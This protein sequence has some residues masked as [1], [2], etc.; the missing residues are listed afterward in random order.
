[1]SLGHRC[2]CGVFIGLVIVG[3]L[4]PASVPLPGRGNLLSAEAAS[5]QV[6]A[7]ARRPRRGR[8]K[9]HAEQSDGPSQPAAASDQWPEAQVVNELAQF[10]SLQPEAKAKLESVPASI[11]SAIKKTGR[12]SAFCLKH[13]G[14]VR[15]AEENGTWVMQLV[16]GQGAAQRGSV[17]STSA[18]TEDKSIPL[19]RP[20]SDAAFLAAIE[21]IK[22]HKIVACSVVGDLRRNGRISLLLVATASKVHV[23]DVQQESSKGLNLLDENGLKMILESTSIVKVM[24]DCS[25]PAD[26]LQHLH[27]VKLRNVWDVRIASILLRPGSGTGISEDLERP[28]DRSSDS[29]KSAQTRGSNRILAIMSSQR[30]ESEWEQRPLPEEMVAQAKARVKSLLKEALTQANTAT[31]ELE[32]E[33]RDRFE[34][35]VGLLRDQAS[36][37]M[38]SL[39]PGET[40]DYQI[41]AGELEL[42]EPDERRAARTPVK[43]LFEHEAFLRALPARIGQQVSSH[44]SF[45]KT[46]DVV[47]DIGRP[48]ILRV[49]G[50][51]GKYE[52]HSLKKGGLIT[53]EDLDEA[54]AKVEPFSRQ[55]RAVVSGSLHRVCALRDTFDNVVGLTVR[56][57]RHVQGNLAPLEDVLQGAV[58]IVGPPGTGKTT[59]LRGIAQWLSSTKGKRVVIVDGS[60]EI[61]GEGQS[62][63]PSV[64]AARRI[65]V[66]EGSRGQETSMIEAVENH[67]PEVIIVDEV[68]SK[69]Q[70]QAARTIGR[71]GVSVVCTCHGNSLWDVIRNNDLGIL[72]GGVNS[73]T[74]SAKDKRYDGLRKT[75]QERFQDPIFK[76]IIEVRSETCWVV[77][78]DAS[79][80]IDEALSGRRPIAELR[81]HRPDGSMVISRIA[82]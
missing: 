23:F 17:V 66:R 20:S 36:V 31:V 5:D 53:Q 78:R 22:T 45:K 41:V 33:L 67:T 76:T 9:E 4:P 14:V 8:R 51:D 44:K 65:M 68:S 48:A 15:F 7:R 71:R 30:A 77:H 19:I 72:I 55:G 62:P 34:Q 80:A 81:E 11:R 12:V 60:N 32:A 49:R 50:V 21:E 58:L 2:I 82:T 42:L 29:V 24:F 69:E 37:G 13:S 63:H 74:L 61:A 43:V 54:C 28:L 40:M 6:P 52:E 59:M 79:K 64:G 27:G 35:E 1:M 3:I 10:L 25:R 73:V 39:G 57:G 56:C 70:A 47:M 38:A 16:S 75:A 18:A 46:V 26:A